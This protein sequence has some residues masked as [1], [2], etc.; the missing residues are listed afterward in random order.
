MNRPDTPHL[1][2]ASIVGLLLDG[3]RA[4]FVGIGMAVDAA[5]DCWGDDD[6]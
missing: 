3:W 1:S 2:P 4:L 6:A 5:M